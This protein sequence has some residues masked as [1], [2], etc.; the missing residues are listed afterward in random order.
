MTPDTSKSHQNQPTWVVLKFGGTSVSSAGNWQTIASQILDGV[1]SGK[2]MMVVHSALANVSNQLELIANASEDY[3]PGPLLEQISRQHLNLAAE[4]DINADIVLAT[5]FEDLKRDIAGRKKSGARHPRT[6]AQIVAHGELLSTRL[7]HAILESLGVKS[8][9][10]DVRSALQSETNDD[11]SDLQN[12]I[13]ATCTFDPDPSLVRQLK[14]GGN[15]VL[16]QGF[17]ARNSLGETVLLGREGS[18]TTAA[19]LAARLQAERVE[20]WTDVPG[21]FSA[22]PRL[23]PSARLLNMLSYEEAQELAST[24]SKVLHPRSISPLRQHGI[25]LLIRCTSMPELPGT[26]ISKASEDSE[27]QLKGLSTR[28]GATLISMQSAAMWHEVGFLADAFAA[29]RKHGVSVDLVSTSETNVTVT[30]DAADDLAPANVLQALITDLE[31][32]CRVRV[33]EDC[34]VV[35]LVGQ[36]IRAILPRLGPA[37]S[38]FEDENIHLV[39]QASNNLN[40]SF[41]I[42][43]PQAPRLLAKL[44]SSIIRSDGGGTLFGP[45][46]E[47]IT[48]GKR[49][50]SDVPDPWWLD[51]REQL[52]KLAELGPG[53]YVYDLDTLRQSVAGLKNLKSIDRVLYAVKANTNPSVIRELSALGVDFD[54]V[55]PG[56]VDELE[57]LLPDL[58]RQRILFT[59]NFAPRSEYQ[60]AIEQ[61]LKLTLDNLYPLQA[62]PELF[63]GQ[64]LFI[65]IDPGKGRGHHDHVITGGNQSKFGVPLFEI[66][67]LVQLVDQANASVIG[68]HTHAGSGILDPEN[69]TSAAES[70]AKVAGRFPDVRVLDLGGGIGVP[71][72]SG[73]EAF[74]LAKFDELLSAFH[75]RHPQFQLWIEPGR[76]LVAQAGVLIS[77]VTQ[78]KGKGDFQYVGIGTGMNSL[79]RPA[80]YGAY[81]EIVNL[82]RIEKKALQTV[83]VVGPICESGDKLG[84]DRLFP[85]TLEGD[86]ILIAN[87]GA[88]G[89]VMASEYNLREIAPEIVI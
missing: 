62:W 41:V 87:T 48:Q 79:I 85:Q 45:S 17:I 19:Y 35:S 9:W 46:W 25:P 51:R 76:F 13:S 83:T 58:D 47:Q 89:R 52:L 61:G 29:F 14:G 60:W 54:C 16:T 11:R 24:G 88:Y 6:H 20:I 18:D 28:S 30:I 86:V 68:L 63:D 72:K 31:Q 36:K 33:V 5:A 2:R 4:F 26:R 44:H 74:D 64:E 10:L 22:D 27:P 82:T 75:D 50:E 70:L 42:D 7:G 49:I 15:V 8:D 84:S 32:L 65:R 57:R 34:A 12:Y 55:S 3:D 38:A 69:W 73:D 71:E 59:P 78:L 77:K 37:L 56:E 21:M 66:D 67:E 39:S 43:A 80:L 53:A 23:V 40:L 1:K 81:H